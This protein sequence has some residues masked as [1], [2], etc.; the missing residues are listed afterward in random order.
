MAHMGEKR[1]AYI[2]WWV[3]LKVKVHVEDLS[4]A[5]RIVLKWVVRK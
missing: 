1:I 5:R 4:M 3:N 2:V